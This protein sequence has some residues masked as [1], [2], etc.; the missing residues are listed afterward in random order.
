MRFS[1]SLL[2]V[3]APVLA[4]SMAR[5]DEGTTALAQLKRGYALK[6]SGQCAQAIAY[7]L[8]SE[9]LDAQPKT[10]LNLSD[11]EVQVGDLVAARQHALEGGELAR[12]LGDRVLVSVADQRLTKLDVRVPRLTI[13]VASGAPADTTVSRDRAAL[14]AASMGVAL[15]VNPGT[16]V[17]VASAE[18]RTDRRY[19]VVVTEGSRPTLDAEPGEE[20]AAPRTV[21]SASTETPASDGVSH[22]EPRPPEEPGGTQAASLATDAVASSSW[23]TG[24]TVGVVLVGAGLAGVAVGS[25]FGIRAIDHDHDS[26]AEGHCDATGCDGTGRQLRDQALSEAT[27][28]TIGFG[29]GVA[30]L[31][32]GLLFWSTARSS[33]VLV[34]PVLDAHR[35]NL[36][37]RGVW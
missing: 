19:E 21:A 11:C 27:A 13:R 36:S 30:S 17:V 15:P 1:H 28:S 10:L 8:D 4:A 26:N 3:L 23:S 16:H 34:E 33:H 12:R 6:Q 32:A 2:V 18:G 5:A 31:L 29:A 37:F 25:V 20:L 22:A 9:R 24:K 35:A 7:F 14:G